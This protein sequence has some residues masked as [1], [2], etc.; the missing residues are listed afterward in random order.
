MLD[1]RAEKVLMELLRT[2]AVED[3]SIPVSM[4]R[5]GRR[6]GGEERWHPE[7]RLVGGVPHVVMVSHN[8]FLRALDENIRKYIWGSDGG[9]RVSYPNTGW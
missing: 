8:V 1:Q 2:W 3:E 4:L 5:C 6:Y 9:G 7:D